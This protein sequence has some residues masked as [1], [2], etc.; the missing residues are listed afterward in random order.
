MLLALVNNKCE[1]TKSEVKLAILGKTL[2]SIN[3]K[4]EA[5]T[6]Y[7]LK[8]LTCQKQTRDLDCQQACAIVER[9]FKVRQAHNIHSAFKTLG[10]RSHQRI[11]PVNM[12]PYIDAAL[13]R[14]SIS[15][16]K[17]ALLHTFILWFQRTKSWHSTRISLDKLIKALKSNELRRKAIGFAAIQKSKGSRIRACQLVWMIFHKYKNIN[18]QY[19]FQH[20]K[21]HTHYSAT[22]RANRN[23]AYR[24]APYYQHK[25][26]TSPDQRYPTKD[27][28]Y[29]REQKHTPNRYRVS[30]E[31]HPVRVTVQ[32]SDSFS[33]LI[34][35]ESKIQNLCETVDEIRKIRQTEALYTIMQFAYTRFLNYYD[36]VISHHS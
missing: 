35:M 12:K 30:T 14:V 1:Q 17:R 2:K 27:D 9:V 26:L 29:Q 15:F 28:S 23:L 7:M 19:G 21:F 3:Q 33:K 22:H 36:R 16:D 32:G 4:A 8:N 20:L 13:D 6:F 5:K 25:E 11:I 31:L 10:Q 34:V 24:P 18:Q